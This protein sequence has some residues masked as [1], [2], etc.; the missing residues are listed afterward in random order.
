MLCGI[1]ANSTLVFF[2]IENTIPTKSQYLNIWVWSWYIVYTQIRCSFSRASPCRL[3][4]L[5][6]NRHAKVLF[7][8]C[9]ISLDT[10]TLISKWS[11]KEMRAI[12]YVYLY[13]YAHQA[14]DL[15]RFPQN[16]GLGCAFLQLLN[17][18]N[19]FLYVAYMLCIMWCS[20]PTHTA[21]T[22]A[23]KKTG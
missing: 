17:T 8:M 12:K 7:Y 19:I 16:R 9:V 22:H 3:W 5:W 20:I 23:A 4:N 18:I 6:W 15:D 1:L 13:V 11:K 2:C 10:L 21:H 14:V